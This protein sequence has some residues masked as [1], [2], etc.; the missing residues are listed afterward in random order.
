MGHVEAG[1]EVGEHR[2]VADRAGPEAEPEQHHCCN[3]QILERPRRADGRPSGEPI[4]GGRGRRFGHFNLRLCEMLITAG[5]MT[6][7]NNAG[8]MQ[9]T[10]GTSILT[11]AFCAR[12]SAS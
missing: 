9:N 5:P 11:G 12:S 1:P 2:V 6:T 4:I 7:T 8:K 10:M 3:E